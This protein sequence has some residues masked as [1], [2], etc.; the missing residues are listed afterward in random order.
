MDIVVVGSVAYDS[1]ETAAGKRQDSLGGSA[2]FFSLS[3][4]S[5]CQPGLVAVVGEDFASSDLAILKSK[6]IG[7]SGL[8]VED[9]DTFRWG[10]VYHEDMNGRDTLFTDF[11]VF[12]T[13]K[14]QLSR[15]ERQSEI[16]FLGNIVPQIQLD[17]LN[18][19]DNP[20]FVAAD[21]MNLWIDIARD[22]L[23]RVLTR[24]DALFINDEEAQQLTGKRSMP[25]AAQAIFNMGPK[26]VIIKRGEHGAIVFSED[27]VFYAPAYP[28]ERVVD[29]TG[30][31]DTFAGGFMGYL[32]K[33]RDFSTANIRRAA[34]VGSLM[35]SFCVEGFGVERLIEVDENDIQ[36]RYQAFTDLTTFLPLEV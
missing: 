9:G 30:A 22:D 14:P 31:G 27:D 33:T 16:V 21:T 17:V 36:R 34:I 7:L 5:F 25:Q 11:N 28:L 1:V 15:E 8:K 24:I 4:A 12:E 3:A 32:T 29:P 20:Q 2:T 6:Q 10:G 35:A 18:Q 26:L 13:F 23:E 19:I